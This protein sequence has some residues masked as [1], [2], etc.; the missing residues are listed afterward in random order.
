MAPSSPSVG[1]SLFRSASSVT[2]VRQVGTAVFPWFT[3][4][5]HF[6]SQLLLLLL[7]GLSVILPVFPL[8]VCVC[9]CVRVCVRACVRACVCVSRCVCVR[10]CACMCVILR[11]NYLSFA[12]FLSFL[13]AHQYISCVFLIGQV[14]KCH[15]AC[16]RVYSY[17]M[18]PK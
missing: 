7:F 16:A 10:V 17:V 15:S 1:L 18:Y 2:S 5:Q 8:R 14:I 6:Q 3:V 11:N 12:V 13:H 9:V 4:R